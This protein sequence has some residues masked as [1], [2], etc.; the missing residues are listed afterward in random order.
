MKKIVNLTHEQ[1]EKY[2]NALCML[3]Q[4]ESRI[5]K[6]HSPEINKAYRKIV[7]DVKAALTDFY[8]NEIAY[9]NMYD[10][11]FN[12]ALVTVARISKRR[13]EQQHSIELHEVLQNIIKASQ[14]GQAKALMSHYKCIIPGCGQKAI[15]SHT[16]SKSNNF[17]V[18]EIF[19]QFTDNLADHY[20][21]PR[22]RKKLIAHKRA[23]TFPLFCLQHDTSLFSSIEMNSNIDVHNPEH[24]HL[25]H[26]R[27]F[28]FRDIQINAHYNEIKHILK[29]NYRS[30][31]IHKIPKFDLSQFY[32]FHH[33]Q[34]S[35]G[36]IN[37][38]KDIIYLGIALKKAPNILASF[39]DDLRYIAKD[40]NIKTP[41]LFYLN[42]LRNRDN[43]FFLLS[44]FDSPAMR[45][46][47]YYYKE[48][49]LNDE[50]EFWQEI[51]KI[52]IL[53]DNVYFEQKIFEDEALSNKLENV[54]NQIHFDWNNPV[55]NYSIKAHKTI[56]KK[57][58]THLF[59]SKK[60]FSNIP[61]TATENLTDFVINIKP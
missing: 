52:L 60:M 55:P 58:A 29:T 7:A 59:K 41:E 40:K 20:F 39:C 23:S 42:I 43:P 48:M 61:E 36:H 57:E 9:N 44:G 14:S 19:Y 32:D 6:L 35:A 28:S 45:K 53:N 38:G 12:A 2:N 1:Q 31:S 26:W 51:M 15:Q 24:L 4:V 10:E 46:T 37:K 17:G 22:P 50:R 13:R 49:F 5:K 56:S 47:L 16:I 30:F 27:T 8:Y 21:Y 11:I 3:E 54:F 34:E 18:N 33:F 25:Q